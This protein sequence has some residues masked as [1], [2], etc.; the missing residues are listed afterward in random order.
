[1]ERRTFLKTA[2]AVVGT[3]GLVCRPA[4]SQSLGANEDVRLAFVGVQRRGSQL[5]GHFR[6]VPGVRVVAL[7]DCDTEFLDR[8]AQKLHDEGTSVRKYVDYRRLIEDKNVD[9]VVIATPDHWHALMTVWACRAGKD[10]YVEKPVSHN[11]S[12]GRMTIEAARR[13]DRV[14][15]AGTQE[16]SDVG[17]IAAARYMA[18]GALGK[19]K[20]GRAFCR[21]FNRSIGKADGSQTLPDTVDYDLFQGPAPIVPLQRKNLHYDWHF[22]WDTGTGDTANRGVHVMDDLWWM[23]GCKRLPLHVVSLGGRFGWDDDGQTPNTHV[24]WFDTE[25]VPMILQVL[26]LSIEN[27]L[28]PLPALRHIPATLIFECEGGCVSARRGGATAYDTGGNV[29]RE[30]PGDG[31]DGHYAKFI[32]AV[33]SRKVE[34]RKTDIAEGHPTTALCHLANISHRTGRKVKPEE[35][36]AADT[37]RLF[38]AEADKVLEHLRSNQI[39]PAEDRVTLGPMLTFDPETER[40]T[41]Q[42][43]QPANR[44]LTRH[45]RPPYTMPEVM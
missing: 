35:I 20:L 12:E 10:V 24:A 1:M 16:R 19:V 22:F 9:A 15:Q 21:P 18:G 36:T 17:L 34:D 45:Y 37:P 33:R 8:E 28:K 41:G 3:T 11:I 39:D 26:S 4:L 30:F 44:Y 38:A 43:S 40:F 29:I 6:K 23:T 25:P 5:I 31:G 42:H 32:K 7:C 27:H 13:Y 2:A 14:V